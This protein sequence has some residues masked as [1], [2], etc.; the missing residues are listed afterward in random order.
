MAGTKLRVNSA[1]A[2]CFKSNSVFC[3]GRLQLWLGVAFQSA[4]GTQM[5]AT[6]WIVN[7]H[8]LDGNARKH[9]KDLRQT[10]PFFLN[11]GKSMEEQNGLFCSSSTKST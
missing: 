3:A 7:N 4:E 5:D 1:N 10:S 2:R 8:L 11:E 6:E 9:A